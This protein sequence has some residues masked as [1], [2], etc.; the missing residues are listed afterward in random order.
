MLLLVLIP[1]P[2]LMLLLLKL[3]LP[4]LTFT[5]STRL[6]WVLAIEGLYVLSDAVTTIGHHLDCE[7]GGAS[8]TP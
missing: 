6:L 7:S 4:L 2:V 5:C 3:M 1:V 8:L